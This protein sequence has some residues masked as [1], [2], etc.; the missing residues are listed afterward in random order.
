MEAPKFE[1]PTTEAPKFEPPTPAEPATTAPPSDDGILGTLKKEKSAIFIKAR[2]SFV[3]LANPKLLRFNNPLTLALLILSLNLCLTTILTFY[4]SGQCEDA[5]AVVSAENGSHVDISKQ[6]NTNIFSTEMIVSVEGPLL[7]DTKLMQDTKYICC[8][9]YRINYN[10]DGG[11]YCP[12]TIKPCIVT[13]GF[14]TDWEAASKTV[15]DKAGHRRLSSSTSKAPSS[16]SS[17][18][19]FSSTSNS[20]YYGS[21]SFYDG[22]FV[23]SFNSGSIGIPLGTDGKPV[24]ECS[25]DVCIGML[26]VSYEV[27]KSLSVAISLATAYAAYADMVITLIVLLI[28]MCVTGQCNRKKLAE[29]QDVIESEA[30]EAMGTKPTKKPT[31]VKKDN[32]D[33][34]STKDL[35]SGKDGKNKKN[36]K[37]KKDA[38]KGKKDKKDKKEGDEENEESGQDVDSDPEDSGNDYEQD[39]DG[40][41]DMT[42]PVTFGF[43]GDE[44]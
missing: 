6:P 31:D 30:N 17:Y 1:P 40:D 16:S 11:G 36:D 19:S 2:K 43:G 39:Y 15:K 8:N 9:D 4:Y 20:P 33:K 24:Q 7:Y 28:Y 5:F 18:S 14:A 22:S 23:T 38:K 12:T 44:C 13:G 25:I 34:K 10:S 27:C 26:A 3:T 42:S 32:K 29:V 37:T 35:K 41:Q 21:F